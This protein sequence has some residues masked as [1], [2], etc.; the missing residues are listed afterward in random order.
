VIQRWGAEQAFSEPDRNTSKPVVFRWFAPP[1][2]EPVYF[3]GIWREWEGDRGTKKAPNVWKHLVFSFLTT[4]PT[5]SSSRCT[6]K[7]CGS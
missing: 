4:E 7:R 1:G 2:G 5:A 3:A 6:P